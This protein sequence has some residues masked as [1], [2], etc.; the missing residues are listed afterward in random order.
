MGRWP[1][2]I[3]DLVP[4]DLVTGATDPFDESGGALRI[5]IDGDDL[6]VYSVGPNGTDEGG[7]I[8][9]PGRK[10]LGVRLRP[11]AA[12]GASAAP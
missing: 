6:V 7:D 3:G 5:A 1:S 4:T 8:D 10:D 11:C 2:T 12:G 9:D